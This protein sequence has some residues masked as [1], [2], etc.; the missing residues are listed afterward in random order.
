MIKLFNKIKSKFIRDTNMSNDAKDDHVIINDNKTTNEQMIVCEQKI[1]ENNPMV[2]E[3]KIAEDLRAEYLTQKFVPKIPLN[4]M[5]SYE[6]K[7]IIFDYGVW[8]DALTNDFPA[9]SE[10][11]RHFSEVAKNKDYENASTEYEKAWVK[12]LIRLDALT[13]N[14]GSPIDDY[15]SYK[16]AQE[17]RVRCY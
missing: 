14:D 12:Y 7:E 3:H 6:E 13:S 16:E 17:R 1:I 11:Q 10:D 4:E 2:S 15:S 8:F 9:Y 5:F